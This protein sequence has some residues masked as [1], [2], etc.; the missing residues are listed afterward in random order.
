MK[1]SLKKWILAVIPL[2]ILGI[3]IVTLVTVRKTKDIS[4][5]NTGDWLNQS[6]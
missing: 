5:G 6:R 4:T 3:I 1:S 2:F